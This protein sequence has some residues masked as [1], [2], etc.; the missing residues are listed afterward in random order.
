M[1]NSHPKPA[2]PAPAPVSRPTPPVA[3]RMQMDR[4]PEGRIQLGQPVNQI[5]PIAPPTKKD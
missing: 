1:K 5:T 2:S 4:P 3:G